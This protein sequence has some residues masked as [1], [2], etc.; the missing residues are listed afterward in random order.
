M[1]YLQ[2]AWLMPNPKVKPPPKAVL[3]E[4]DVWTLFSEALISLKL[5]DASGPITALASIEAYFDAAKRQH[6]RICRARSSIERLLA[7]KPTATRGSTLFQDVHFYLISWVRIA[8]LAKFIR[9]QT[10]FSRTGLVLRRYNREIQDKTDARDHL[11]HFEDRL[12]GG[13]RHRHLAVPSD[14]LNMTN[15]YL[16]FGGC[17]VDIGPNS[18]LL[19]KAFRDDLYDAV[20]FDSAEVLSQGA[21]ERFSALL[22]AA[23]STVH[24]RRVAKRVKD[25]KLR[26]QISRALRG[27]RKGVQTK[28]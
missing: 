21:S 10:R 7:G 9:D 5:P 3:R 8:K 12:P 15:R 20:L 17:R 4:L 24:L 23:A 14:L 25:P 22:R 6:R 28:N 16:T 11:E 19:L 26:K 13:K 1:S 27:M 2:L 18:M